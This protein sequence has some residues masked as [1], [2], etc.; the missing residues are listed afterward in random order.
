[1]L[2]ATKLAHCDIYYTLKPI[3][4]VKVQSTI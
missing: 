4:I 2:Y 3:V 1:M